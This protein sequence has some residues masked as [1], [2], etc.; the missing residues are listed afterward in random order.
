M[1][2]LPA[3]SDEQCY[4]ACGNVTYAY[5]LCINWPYIGLCM[6]SHTQT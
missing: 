1:P 6:V 5:A 2:P 4:T 3:A